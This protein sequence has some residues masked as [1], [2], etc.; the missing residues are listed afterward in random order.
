MR[1]L[2]RLRAGKLRESRGHFDKR[3]RVFALRGWLGVFVTESGDVH[4][5]GELPG[6]HGAS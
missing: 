2:A 1:A 5:G 6:G 3:S 4:S